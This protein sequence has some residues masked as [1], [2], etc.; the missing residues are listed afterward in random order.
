MG[1]SNTVRNAGSTLTPILQRAREKKRLDK[2][3]KQISEH[4]HMCQGE[5]GRS[6]SFPYAFPNLAFFEISISDHFQT[7]P[8]HC[9]VRTLLH[10]LH[11]NAFSDMLRST[12]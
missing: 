5:G 6:W 4:D 1:V 8:P 12:Y 2:C 11:N 3:I 10:G 7:H 9:R